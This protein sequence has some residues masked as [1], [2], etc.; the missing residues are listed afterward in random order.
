MFLHRSKNQPGSG[1]WLIMV[2]SRDAGSPNPYRFITQPILKI[3]NWYIRYFPF[4]YA[5]NVWTNCIWSIIVTGT[6]LSDAGQLFSVTISGGR[7]EIRG[8]A[9]QI[10]LRP[11]SAYFN[12]WIRFLRS[13]ERGG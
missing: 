9:V 7:S 8:T 1:Q 11:S 13:Y 12:H 10:G 4:G 5:E 2:R 6:D 3:N